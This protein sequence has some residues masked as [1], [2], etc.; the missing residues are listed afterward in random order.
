MS[1]G[2]FVETDVTLPEEMVPTV[3]YNIATDE[4]VLQED[5][6]W[7][8]VR[9]VKQAITFDGKL[10]YIRERAIKSI[11]KSFQKANDTT[12]KAI[13]R[14]LEDCGGDFFAK[15]EFE[16]TQYLL[17]K[18]NGEEVLEEESHGI[19]EDVEDSQT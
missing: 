7:E 10:W 11:D 9:T 2:K 5:K 16:G 1:E 19:V 15:R 8:I 18:A 14:I 17:E 3:R 6:S 12:H 4:A 13:G